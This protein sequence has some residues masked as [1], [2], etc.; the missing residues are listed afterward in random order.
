MV[1]DHR[2]MKNWQEQLESGF[3]I[4][5]IDWQAVLAPFPRPEN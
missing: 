1:F 3:L 5:D 2:M 4:S